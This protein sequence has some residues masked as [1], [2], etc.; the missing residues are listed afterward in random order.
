MCGGVSGLDGCGDCGGLGCVSK[1]GVSQCGGEG[2]ET[3]VTQSQ[4][5]LNKAKNLDQEVLHTLKEVDKLNKMVCIHNNSND[6]NLLIYLN[7]CIYTYYHS[8]VL[9]Q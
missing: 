7:S 2:C 5:A 8:K 3:I 1:D 4:E 6:H 9:G